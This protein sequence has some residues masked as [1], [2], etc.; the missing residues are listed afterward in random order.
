MTAGLLELLRNR[1]SPPVRRK[2]RQ[3]LQRLA[4]PAWLH[5]FNRTTPLSSHFGND[6]GTP[7]DRHYIEAFLE[8]HRAD[9]RGRGLEVKDTKYLDRFGS[10]LTH[11]DVLD[12]D[13][14]NPQATLV[15][16]LATAQDL[17]SNQFDCIVLTQTLQYVFDVA[18]AVRHLHRMLRPGGVLLVTVPSAIALLDPQLQHLEQ[19]RFTVPSCRRLF[20]D[21]FGEDAIDVRAYGNMLAARAFLAGMACEELSPR[22]LAAHDPLFPIVV[23]VRAVKRPAG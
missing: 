22:H 16:D 20:S 12:I 13:P 10:G 14:S 18:A 19:W 15:A 5:A 3:R 4:R 23:S 21:A 9:I 2:I 17:P 6:R 11:V 1:V 7:V 8:Q